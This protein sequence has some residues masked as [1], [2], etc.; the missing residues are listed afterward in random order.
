VQL[1][2]RP[3][4]CHS[5]SIRDT[6]TRGCFMLRRACRSMRLCTRL[7][8]RRRIGIDASPNFSND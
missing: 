3:A 6:L 2:A 4:A 5:D 8:C 7:L 1:A